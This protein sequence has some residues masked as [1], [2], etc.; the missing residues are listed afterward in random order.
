MWM[1]VYSKQLLTVYTHKLL[2]CSVAVEVWSQVNQLTAA[3]T[4]NADFNHVSIIDRWLKRCFTLCPTFYISYSIAL[5][6]MYFSLMFQL[7]KVLQQLKCNRSLLCSGPESWGP[8]TE[9]V[10]G[11]VTNNCSYFVIYGWHWSGTLPPRLWHW[12][13]LGEVV[14]SFRSFW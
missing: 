9:A 10:H 12:C 11:C 7:L 6:W 13:F 14:I 4:Q 5:N 2:V 8:L 1:C 3:E